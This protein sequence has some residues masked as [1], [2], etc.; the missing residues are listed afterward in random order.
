MIVQSEFRDLK[1][2][3]GP[4]R[5]YVYSPAGASAS[6]K[7]PGILLYPEIFQ[8]TGPIV[9]LSQQFAAHGYLVMAPEIYHEHEPLGPVL[10][11]D[12]VGR[13]KG[14]A[15]KHKTKL[16]TFDN[17]AKVVIRALRENPLCNGRIGTVGFCI[18]GHLAFRAA[19]NPD[20]LAACCFYPTDLHSGALGEGKNA[21]S[22]QRASELKGEL[23]VIWGR[24]DP[25]IPNEGRAKIYKGLL[26]AGVLFSW[27][28]FNA[29]HAFMRDEG[30]RYDAEAARICIGIA[31]GLFNRVL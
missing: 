19:L 22:L 11:Y 9:R 6:N 18:G 2:P 26:D 4:M 27:H 7:V 3:T 25:H 8:Q 31:L 30:S 20:I 16:S 12:D 21:D 29:E 13:D 5:T 14:N 28:E 15:Y 10:A 24:Q 1:T 23:V 17:D